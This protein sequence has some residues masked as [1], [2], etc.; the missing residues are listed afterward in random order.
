MIKRFGGITMNEIYT[1]VSVRK[2]D[3]YV[4]ELVFTDGVADSGG[5][6]GKIGFYGEITEVSAIAFYFQIC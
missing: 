5:R 6:Y 4:G 3:S 2:F 1:R